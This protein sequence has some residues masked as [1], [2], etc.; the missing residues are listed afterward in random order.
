MKMEGL[1]KETVGGA[2]YSHLCKLSE[3]IENKEEVVD[4]VKVFQS[5][6]VL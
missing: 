3:M 2:L 5:V 4:E 6:L 1:Q